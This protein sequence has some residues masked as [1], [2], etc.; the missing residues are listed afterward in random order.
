[1]PV[2]PLKWL[3]Y[4]DPRVAP[5]WRS[6]PGS[7][8]PINYWLRHADHHLAPMCRSV[9]RVLQLINRTRV[10]MF[11]DRATPCLDVSIGWIYVITPFSANTRLRSAYPIPTL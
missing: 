4:A 6:R 5:L 3:L 7:I 8:T 9:T 10:L 11:L 2:P 1:M